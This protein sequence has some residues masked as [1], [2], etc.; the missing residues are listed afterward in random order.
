MTKQHGES[1]GI[2]SQD[3][4]PPVCKEY[5]ITHIWRNSVY[6]VMDTNEN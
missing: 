4:N 3:I 5:A 2:S 6:F 1:Q